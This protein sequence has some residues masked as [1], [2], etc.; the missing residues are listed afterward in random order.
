MINAYGPTETTVCATIGSLSELSGQDS[1]PIGT[2]IGEAELYVLGA[3]LELLP[4]GA[5][6]EL[7]IAGPVLARGYLGRP[8]L[9]AE[10]FV[11]CPFGRPGS[12]MYRTG[13][14]VRWRADGQLEYLGR[15]D[16]QVKVR[17]FRVELGEI[18]AVLAR[19]EA[20]RNVVVV[21]HEHHTGDNRLVAYVVASDE[22][23]VIDTAQLR[24]RVQDQLPSYMLPSVIVAL[25]ELPLL[26]NG[27]VNR[28]ALPAPEYGS[29]TAHEDQQTPEEAAL[30]ELFG[31]LLGVAEVATSDGFFDLGGHSLIA[32]KLVSRVAKLWGV[33][34][35]LATV[36]QRPTP[37][38]LAEYLTERAATAIP[39]SRVRRLSHV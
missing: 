8:G 28:R 5:A 6:G 17:G 12:R 3:N 16:H 39:S 2:P 27:K 31:E 24:R 4:P 29:S 11:G 25:P 21:L 32:A 38:A 26:P 1:V 20:V 22:L 23:G 9:T 35:S 10:R 37:A 15:T 33:R 18:E 14:L 36:F 13:D 34:L 19:D 7:Y 30:C